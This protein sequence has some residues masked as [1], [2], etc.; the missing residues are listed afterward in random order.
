MY[1]KIIYSSIFSFLFTGSVLSQ[2]DKPEYYRWS[3]GISA[4]DI[5]QNLFNSQDTNRSYA[6]F[7]LE[8]AWPKYALQAGF[9]P[10]YNMTNTEHEGFTD[11]EV[12]H[13]TTFSGSLN[14]TRTIFSDQ[15]WSFAA[16][17]KY[18]GGRSKED[19]IKD[20]GFDVVTTR[21]L[22]WNAGIGPVVDVRFY[23]HSRF[24]LGTEASLLYTYY[25]S[26]LQQ[27]YDNF[28]DFDTTTDKVTANKV[29]VF[30][31]MTIYLRFH[32]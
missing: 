21:R 5:F 7:V 17:L 18:S 12:T 1:K 23:V 9:R 6:A 25:E 19:I 32:F 16:G 15:R 31:P 27:L 2:S 24:S 22:E 11:S 20:S 3:F 29:E 4:G 26:E 8:Y 13:K 10:G 30:E 14:F 28:P